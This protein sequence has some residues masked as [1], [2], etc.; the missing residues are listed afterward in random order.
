LKNLEF[1]KN[2]KNFTKGFF[3]TCMQ[4]LKGNKTYLYVILV[5]YLYAKLGLHKHKVTEYANNKFPEGVCVLLASVE[6]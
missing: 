6:A 4:K 2:A 1:F 3:H 5:C